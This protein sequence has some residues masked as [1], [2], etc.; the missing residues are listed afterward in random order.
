MCYIVLR[1][2]NAHFYQ[3]RLYSVLTYDKLKD[4]VSNQLIGVKI[5]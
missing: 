2:F 1:E 5:V 3:C 4:K